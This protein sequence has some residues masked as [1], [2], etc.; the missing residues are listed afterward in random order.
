MPSILSRR[1]TVLIS[2]VQ[3][4]QHTL[5]FATPICVSIAS[6]L[7]LSARLSMSMQETVYKGDES[8]SLLTEVIYFLWASVQ[9]DTILAILWVV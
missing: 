4:L 1:I 9:E 6:P 7:L 2:A 3:C 8:V 5:A